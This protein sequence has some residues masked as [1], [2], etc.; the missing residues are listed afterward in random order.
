METQ[1]NK[2]YDATDM[3]KNVELFLNGRSEHGRYLSFEHCY[4]FFQ[5]NCKPKMT[6]EI[7]DHAALHLFAYLASWGMMR[8]SFLMYKDYKYLTGLID[9]LVS[10]KKEEYL[11]EEILAVKQD[12]ISFF[13]GP[14]DNPT[15]FITDSPS[16]I[17][18]RNRKNWDTLTSKIL[19]GT[20]GCVPAY[21][22]YFKGVAKKEFNMSPNFN[23]KGLDQL[24]EFK[25][26]NKEALVKLQAK[27]KEIC[28][29]EY[30]VMKIIDMYFWQKGYSENISL[31]PRKQ[32]KISSATL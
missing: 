5:N 31:N 2:S 14:E 18:V 20:L 25:E 11:S 16:P 13:I 4:L 27:T 32:S 17:L 8:N 15:T 19:M 7:K 9:V 23:K 12:I 26:Q 1:S 3:E 6:N 28:G 22:D 24:V 21:D 30:P 29:F 10:H